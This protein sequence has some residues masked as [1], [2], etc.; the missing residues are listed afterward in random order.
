MG[1]AKAKAKFMDIN[2]DAFCGFLNLQV[3]DSD[4]YS[5]KTK[6]MSQQAPLFLV[7]DPA[8]GD[9]VVIET[10]FAVNP[11]F[12]VQ[13]PAEE[14]LYIF[15]QWWIGEK[16]SQTSHICT[17][18]PKA[19]NQIHKEMEKSGTTEFVLQAEMPFLRNASSRLLQATVASKEQRFVT[20][21][22]KVRLEVPRSAWMEWKEYRARFWQYGKNQGG[23]G[24]GG[25]GGEEK[26]DKDDKKKD[27]D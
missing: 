26:E 8:S 5:K 21:V 4:G 15:G 23:A 22:A 17:T 2:D 19:C 10:E 16:F 9:P 6:G 20:K 13:V 14:N 7:S 18:I 25:G 12:Y 3:L 11:L 27:E 1:E 24:G